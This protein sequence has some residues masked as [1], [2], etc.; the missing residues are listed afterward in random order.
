MDA[1]GT[2]AYDGCL[3]ASAWVR[4]VGHQTMGEAARTVRTARTL[5]SGVLPNTTA[6]L[7]AGAIGW[8][9]R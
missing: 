7:A 3:S 9:R 5:R 1:D 4:A 8:T 6:A 2:H